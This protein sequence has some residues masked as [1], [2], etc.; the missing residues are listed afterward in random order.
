M[1]IEPRT[2]DEY[3]MG[4]DFSE[5]ANEFR[6]EHIKGAEQ[7]TFYLS[8][9]GDNFQWQLMDHEMALDVRA[10]LHPLMR[11]T[12]LKMLLNIHSTLV[13]GRIGRFETNVMTYVYPTNGKLVDRATRYAKAI[14]S[15][16]GVSCTYEEV[17]HQLFKEME[18]IKPGESVVLKI[19]DSLG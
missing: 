15:D 7:E 17:V 5:Q 13:M 11:H 8:C 14:L 1:N 16:R 10:G 4:F 19:V 6:S 18:K 3:T 2:S 12:L 9:S